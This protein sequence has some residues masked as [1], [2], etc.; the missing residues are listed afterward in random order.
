VLKSK[1]GHNV[2][3]SLGQTV[4]I[5]YL[6][7]MTYRH[8]LH[9]DDDEDDQE[10][11]QTALNQVTTEVVYIP[12][13][14]PITALEQLSDGVLIADIIFLDLNMPE[15]NGQQFLLELKKKSGLGDIPVIVLSTSSHN[16]TIQLVKELGARDFITKPTNFK[17]FIQLLQTILQ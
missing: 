11:F 8:I 10:I 13:N 12:V 1:P 16:P 4:D 15:M 3:E 14:S 5:A 7:L 2:P 9:I 17:E 6:Y